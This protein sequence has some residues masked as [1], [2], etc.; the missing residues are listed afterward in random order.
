MGIDLVAGLGFSVEPI[1]TG[2]I[3]TIRYLDKMTLEY[4][5]GIEMFELT[6]STIEQTAARN[7]KAHKTVKLC[8]LAI[9]GHPDGET[10]TSKS[11]TVGTDQYELKSP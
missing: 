10:Y 2:I 5:C 7:S 11:F 4:S 8:K 3:P 9:A 1:S 6:E